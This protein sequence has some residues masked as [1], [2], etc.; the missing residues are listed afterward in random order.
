MTMNDLYNTLGIPRD[1]S[2]TEVKKAFRKLARE[3]HPDVRPDDTVAARRFR[4][5]REAYETLED[6]AK[7]AKYDRT[8]V[9]PEMVPGWLDLAMASAMA[10]IRR[11]EANPVLTIKPIENAGTYMPDFIVNARHQKIY[12]NKTENPVEKRNVKDK[13]KG[14]ENRYGLYLGV[15]AD[16]PRL[17]EIQ[18]RDS[19]IEGVI[20][21]NMILRLESTSIDLVLV[22]VRAHITASPTCKIDYSGFEK[23]G[24]DYIRKGSFKLL[25]VGVTEPLEKVLRIYSAGC[26]INLKYRE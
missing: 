4:E 19:G 10:E 7:R 15:P 8:T 24:T 6:P 5:I 25:P 3:V 11:E 23:E 16:D 22:G 14:V 13:V 18:A 1:A 21:K 12:L 17:I 26:E 2:L 9:I 20:G